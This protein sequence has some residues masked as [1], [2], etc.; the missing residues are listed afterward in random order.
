MIK[1][2]KHRLTCDCPACLDTFPPD[3]FE[4]VWNVPKP[5]VEGARPVRGPVPIGAARPAMLFGLWVDADQRLL[6]DWPGFAGTA[7][8]RVE[9]QDRPGAPAVVVGTRDPLLAALAEPVPLRRTFAERVGARC[10]VEFGVTRD[11]VADYLACDVHGEGLPALTCA[12][13]ADPAAP[14]A[15]AV[16]VYGLD[17][18]FPDAFCPPCLE[19]FAA[20]DVSVCQTVCSR[21]QQA[22]VYRHRVTATTWY[23]AK[24]GD[25][26]D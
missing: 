20:G 11:D 13:L 26:P 22:N 9:L 15:E 19:R 14:P 5:E 8:A 18:D 4:A 7:G 6:H 1:V 3:R 23:G 17:G 12:H 24:P 16:V 2:H 25:V 21:C 10:M